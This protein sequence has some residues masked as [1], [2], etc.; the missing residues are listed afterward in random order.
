MREDATKKSRQKLYKKLTEGNLQESL[1]SYEEYTDVFSSTDFFDKILK[2]T[3]YRIGD[4]WATGKIS[5]ATEHVASNIAQTLVRI[6]M[7]QVTGSGKKKKILICV[8]LGEEHHLGCDVLETYLT[9][10]GFKIY[11]MGTSMPTESILS[12]IDCRK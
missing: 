12:F 7:D 4:E 6:I 5:I 3:M 11:N 2:P 8:P 9:I 1:K 10:K